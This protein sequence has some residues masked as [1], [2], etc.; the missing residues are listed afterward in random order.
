MSHFKAENAPNSI[1]AAA[2]PQTALPSPLAGFKRGL[3]L[4]RGECRKREKRGG[5][6]GKKEGKREG[7]GEGEG[8]EWGAS[9]PPKDLV[10]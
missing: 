6:N 2:P 9:G 10:K 7:R 4:R 1:S 8:K 5:E 3:L